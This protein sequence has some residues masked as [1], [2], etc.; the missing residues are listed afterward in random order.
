MIL[1]EILERATREH[2]AVG[3]FNAS[4]LEQMQVI[5]RT[6]K[7]LGSPVMIGTSEGERN[8]IGLFEA[9][10]LRDA[11][12]KEFGIPLFLNADHTKSV[13]AAK[14][15]VDA[16]YDSIHIDL[17]A[18]SFEDNMHGTAEI[19][20]YARSHDRRISIEGE[21]GY[22]QGESK[23]EMKKLE[24]KPED[25]TNPEQARTF[26]RETGV[27]RFAPAVGNSHGINLDEPELD[28][29]R[30]RAIRHLIP[31]KVAIVLHGGS[32]IPL[33][34]IEQAVDAGVGNIHVNTEL[35]IA[36]VGGL[37]ESIAAHPGETT[38]YKLFPEAEEAMAKVVEEKIKLF[39]ATDKV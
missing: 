7:R 8:H 5:A 35:R 31:E 15:A 39:R 2:W 34:E 29:D 16:G 38:P 1:N 30:I 17:S 12:R 25:Y 33:G 26:V 10:A 14:L 21:L 18:K 28:I 23:I 36:F 13:E 37:R 20:A 32:G 6:A 4:N 19:A 9:V 27:D 3:H 11:L 24:M 22:L